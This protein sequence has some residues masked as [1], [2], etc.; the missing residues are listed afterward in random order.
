TG[1]DWAGAGQV[2]V[3]TFNPFREP[4]PG[5]IEATFPDL[6]IGPGSPVKILK[7]AKN[8]KK[9]VVSGEDMT[10]RVIP[11]AKQIN[12]TWFKARGTNSANWMRNQVQWIRRQIQDPGTTIIDIG[13]KG[14]TPTSKYYIKE[15][16]MIQKWLGL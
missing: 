16:E 6:P 3:D 13:P 2:I 14:P 9:I 8:V 7:S 11:Y 4:A 12:A 15:L 5:V 10:N 1:L